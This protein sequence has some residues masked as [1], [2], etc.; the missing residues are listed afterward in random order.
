MSFT[1]NQSVWVFDRPDA[2]ARGAW[3]PGTVLQLKPAG[4]ITIYLVR[5]A[6]G[7]PPGMYG[8]WFKAHQLRTEEQHAKRLL[9]L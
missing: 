2:G 5:L 8:A 6:N 7:V 1:V 3:F 9:M 4:P